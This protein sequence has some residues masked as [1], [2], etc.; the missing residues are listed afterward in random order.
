[1]NA[2]IK[3]GPQL[4]FLSQMLLTGVR[5]FCLSALSVTQV[6][7][8]SSCRGA[9]SAGGSFWGGGAPQLVVGHG[10]TRVAASPK[11]IMQSRKDTPSRREFVERAP[12]GQ[13]N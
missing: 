6:C 1:M 10:G 3:D 5:S 13:S 11:S 9:F 2:H 8:L 7:L 12:S 4:C